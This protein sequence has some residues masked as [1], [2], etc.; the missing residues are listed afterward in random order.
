MNVSNFAIVVIASNR[1]IFVG[2][3][4]MRPRVLK[5]LLFEL[6]DMAVMLLM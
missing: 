3:S 5:V 6:N 1:Q 2:E 4:F